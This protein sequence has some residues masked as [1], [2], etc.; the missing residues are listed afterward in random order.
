MKIT[1]ICHSEIIKIDLKENHNYLIFVSIL[2]Y[3][4]IT[5]IIVSNCSSSV[6]YI[7]FDLLFYFLAMCCSSLSVLCY[8]I[9]II[10]GNRFLLGFLSRGSLSLCF[11]LSSPSPH[12]LM[13]HA[14]L[15][16]NS[17]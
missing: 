13:S 11:R 1:N 3:Q 5:F 14:T 2:L 10:L 15:S 16:F 4:S 8:L 17:F 12:R 7:L 9:C 6:F